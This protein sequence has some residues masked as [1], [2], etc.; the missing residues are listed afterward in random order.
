MARSTPPGVAARTKGN[1]LWCI[2]RP[3]LLAPALAQPGLAPARVI[4][5]ETGDDKTVLA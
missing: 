5:V 3:D 2:T 1:V 4:Y